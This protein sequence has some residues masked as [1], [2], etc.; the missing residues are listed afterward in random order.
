MENINFNVVQSGKTI[1]HS[2]KR[3]LHPWFEFEDYY[4]LHPTDLSKAAV[5]D[6]VIGKAAAMLAMRFGVG[7]IH[8]GVMSE[9]ARES[10]D[11]ASIPYTYKLKVDR[12]DCATEE[13]LKQINDPEAAYQILCK[14]AKRC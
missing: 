9:L 11:Q 3:W 12:I 4:A 8:A 5:H 7:H 14:R 10:L 1:F 2:E 6:K 13:I